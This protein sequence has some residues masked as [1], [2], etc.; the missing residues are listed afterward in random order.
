MA[1]PTIEKQTAEATPEQI[2]YANILN[3][4]MIAGIIILVI[5]FFLYVSG[6]AKPFIPPEQIPALWGGKAKEFLAATG[7]PKGWAWLGYL[8]KGDYM[9]YIGIALL[10]LL[11]ILGYL[12]LLPAY[13]RKKDNV[14]ALLVIAEIVVLSLAAAG[15]VGGG[16]H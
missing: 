11:S 10:S 6:I 5:T 12:V 1:V 9:N 2:M 3:I 4:G 14:Y 16:G 13:I 15:L 7:G 8:G